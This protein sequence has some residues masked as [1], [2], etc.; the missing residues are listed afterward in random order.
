MICKNWHH[1]GYSLSS[2]LALGRVYFDDVF[3][4]RL[5]CFSVH[6]RNSIFK[7]HRFQMASLW[8]AFSNG[9][10]FGDRFWHCSVDDSRIQSKRALFSFENGLVWTGP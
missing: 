2:G 1:F 7:K 4:F 10:V 8:R 9:S 5:H 6:T 3:V